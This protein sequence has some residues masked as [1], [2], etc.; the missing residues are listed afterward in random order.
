VGNNGNKKKAKTLI[1]YWQN[2][3]FYIVEKSIEYQKNVTPVFFVSIV[4]RGLNSEK[5]DTCLETMIVSH[6]FRFDYMK[7]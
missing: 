5:T 2:T 6:C 7:S 1:V 3:F 4:S